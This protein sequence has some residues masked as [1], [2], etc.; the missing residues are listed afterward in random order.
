MSQLSPYNYEKIER[1][2]ATL[3][4]ANESTTLFSL[5]QVRG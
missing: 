5:S 1:I 3:E 4:A 2:L